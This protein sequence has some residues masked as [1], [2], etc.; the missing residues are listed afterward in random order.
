MLLEDGDGFHSIG[1]GL[2]KKSDGNESKCRI[3][4]CKVCSRNLTTLCQRE[5]VKCSGCKFPFWFC[6]KLVQE[7][8]QARRREGHDLADDRLGEAIQVIENCQ[9]KFALYMKHRTIVVCEHEASKHYERAMI[10]S[11]EETKEYSNLWKCTIDFKMKFEGV[12]AHETMP[13]NF[14]K[15]GMGWH[16]AAV[17]LF[18]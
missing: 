4:S 6:D 16:G 10:S 3:Y 8:E 12:S 15:R 13:E 5:V 7:Y 1:H 17:E 14:G 2:T 18:K 11:A 9:D